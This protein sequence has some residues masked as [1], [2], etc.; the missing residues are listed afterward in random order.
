MSKA[1]SLFTALVTGVAILLFSLSV[2]A[3]SLEFVPDDMDVVIGNSFDVDLVIS[4]LGDYSAVSLGTFDL[5]V[6]FDSSILQFDHAAFG[7]PILGDQLDLFGLGAVTFLDD[8][9]P[10]QVSLS[11]L[12]FDLE[13]D[14]NNMQPSTFT[15]ATLFFISI[16]EGESLL[17]IADF[18]TLG[19]AAGDPLTLA[20]VN[21][22]SINVKPVP[23]P[24]TMLLFTTGLIGL[25][26][27]RRRLKK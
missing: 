22:A 6:S 4:G 18:Y 12:S 8:A 10:G 21:S 27:F 11:E 24:T 16:G 26:G 14:L 2:Q 25:A 9:V 13:I 17:N 5:I 20:S 3:I 15:L 19:D 1:Y 23:E 7:D